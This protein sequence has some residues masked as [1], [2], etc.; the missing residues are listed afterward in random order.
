MEGCCYQMK[1][2]IEYLNPTNWKAH[3]GMVPMV[4]LWW[5]S[6]LTGEDFIPMETKEVYESVNTRYLVIIS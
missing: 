3:K 2:V 6:L 4:W 1:K 5:K